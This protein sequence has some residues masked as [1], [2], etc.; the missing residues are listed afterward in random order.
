MLQ[1]NLDN[2]D[3]LENKAEILFNALDSLSTARLSH[4]AILA[5]DLTTYLKHV[6][7]VV[8]E[9]YPGYELALNQVNHYY[10]MN[11]VSFVTYD[12][13]LYVQCTYNYLSQI[14]RSTN[15]RPI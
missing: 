7:E 14:E 9:S 4:H 13:V 11:M 2:Y 12:S 15:F 6:E 3:N 8:E 10:D 1:R 5:S